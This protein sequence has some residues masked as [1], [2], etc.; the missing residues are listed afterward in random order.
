MKDVVDTCREAGASELAKA[1]D[2]VGL[3]DMLKDANYTIFAP[4]DDAFLQYKPEQV[5][6]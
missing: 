2:S 4:I 3:T 1:F 6:L 5:W